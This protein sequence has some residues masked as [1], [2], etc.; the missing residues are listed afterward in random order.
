MSDRKIEKGETS[1]LSVGLDWTEWLGL[2]TI[3]S[4]VWDSSDEITITRPQSD[5]STTACYVG[6][7]VLGKSYNITNTI[8]TQSGRKDS[9][10]IKIVIKNLSV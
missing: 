2:D 4:S 1:V 3:I 8:E 10:Y 7:G 6:G 5:N 9:R